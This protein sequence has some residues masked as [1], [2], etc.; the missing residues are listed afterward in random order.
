MTEI[1]WRYV[2]NVRKEVMAPHKL[3][4]DAA[5]GT[6]GTV[7]IDATGFDNVISTAA[8]S[9]NLS[10]QREAQLHGRASACLHSESSAAPC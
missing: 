9:L 2:D 4:V 5:F 3:I 10:A 7:V 6:L 8:G 1:A